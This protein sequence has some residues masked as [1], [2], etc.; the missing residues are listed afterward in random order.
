MIRA[1]GGRMSVLPDI[2]TSG[3]TEGS[4]ALGAAGFHDDRQLVDRR[5]AMTAVVHE[6]RVVGVGDRLH[7]HQEVVDVHAM[8]RTFV[9][10]GILRSHE[11]VAGGNQRELGR[12]FRR[13]HVPG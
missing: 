9:F 2:R 10:L 8:N 4:L 6:A 11:E 1:L 12:G 3:L 13:R 7:A 5:R